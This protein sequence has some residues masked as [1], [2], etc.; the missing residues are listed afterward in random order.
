[1]KIKLTQAIICEGKYDKI[2]LSNIFDA[3]IL[4]TEGFGIFKDDEKRDLVKRLSETVGIIIVTDSDSA[5]FVIRNHIKSFCD[6]EKITNVYIP[7]LKGR[8]KRK[9]EESK[10]GLLGVEGISDDIIISAFER[11]GVLGERKESNKSI[12]K[13][14]L[15][16]LSLVGSENS[17]LL[18]ER[19]YESLNLPKKLSP[20]AFLEVANSLFSLEE[21]KTELEKLK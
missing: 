15:Y 4:T 10:E 19:L 3:T 1:M 20:N 9:T 13:T 8:E 7:E 12:T 6:N 21:I 16:N 18:R 11:A 5:G 14:D 17:S 2:K